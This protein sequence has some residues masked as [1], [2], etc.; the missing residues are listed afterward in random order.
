[1]VAESDIIRDAVAQGGVRIVT[2]F[3]HPGTGEIELV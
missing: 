2:A 3:Y 1:L